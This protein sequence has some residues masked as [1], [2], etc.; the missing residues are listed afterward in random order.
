MSNVLYAALRDEK[1]LDK[2]VEASAK[3]GDSFDMKVGGFTGSSAG[4]PIRIKGI[5]KYFGPAHGYKYVAAIEFG[6]NN[7]LIITPAYTQIIRPSQLKFGGVNPEKYKVFV[8]K[9]RVHF[10]RGFD[11]TGYAKK[12]IVVDTPEPWVGTTRLNALDYKFA[13]IDQLYPFNR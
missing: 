4:K 8:V 1:A 6:R 3:P 7:M 2:L 12:I 9:S 5:V 10:R 13:P 11:E